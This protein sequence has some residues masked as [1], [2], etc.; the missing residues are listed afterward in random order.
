VFV[1]LVLLGE[2]F[3]L[4]KYTLIVF[5]HVNIHFKRRAYILKENKITS[6][7]ISFVIS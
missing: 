5:S 3:V 6:N 4:I 7:S 2:I 1:L